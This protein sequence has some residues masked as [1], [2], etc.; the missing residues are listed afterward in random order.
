MALGQPNG[1]GRF[2]ILERHVDENRGIVRRVGSRSVWLCLFA[3]VAFAS[4]V[5]AQVPFDSPM[6]NPFED[7]EQY[8]VPQP[9]VAPRQRLPTIN[10]PIAVEPDL[11]PCAEPT[12]LAELLFADGRQSP[13]DYRSGSFQ[14]LSFINTY[15]PRKGGGGYGTEDAEITSVWGLPLPSKDSPLVITPGFATHWVDGPDQRDIPA[16]LHDAYAEF[17]WLP[18]IA[19]SFRADLA[20]QPGYYSDWNGGTARAFRLTGHASG[21]FNATHDLQFVLGVAYLDRTDTRMLPIVGL[22][23][24]PNL[25]EEYRLVFPSPKLSYRIGSD[26]LRTLGNAGKQETE[27]WIYLGGELGGGTWA[28]RH[29]DGTSD[30]MSYSDW[31]V[32]LGIE[33]RSI[34]MASSQIEVGYVFHRRIR[35]E[36]LGDDFDVGTTLMVRGGLSF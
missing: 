11:S 25:D 12:T 4:S 29:S 26:A 23:W 1:H 15:L 16:Q 19:E 31:R 6:D 35:L 36:S 10:S 33:T 21:I 22:I 20:V 7:G 28:I 24:K 17:R 27:N 3:C 14:K 30:L 8:A 2:E 13:S 32:F 18:Q 9:L 5:A 34:R